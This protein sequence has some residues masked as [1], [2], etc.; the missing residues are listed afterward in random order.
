TVESCGKTTGAMLKKFHETW[1]VP[2]NAVLV[3]VGDVRP[4]QTLA[5]VKELFGPIP[6]KKTPAKPAIRL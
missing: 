5:R 1:Y 3:I 4:A 2:N 6:A